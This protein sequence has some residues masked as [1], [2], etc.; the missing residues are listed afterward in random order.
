MSSNADVVGL[1]P[2]GGKPMSWCQTDSDVTVICDL[3]VLMSEQEEM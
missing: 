2:H 1:I 3:I